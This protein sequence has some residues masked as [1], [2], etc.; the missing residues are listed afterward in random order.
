M[1]YRINSN[2]TEMNVTWN[3]QPSFAESYGSVDIVANDSWGYVNL[4]VTTLVQAWVNGSYPNYGIML[5]GPEVSGSDSSWREFYTR[6]GSYVP[7]LVITY[8]GTTAITAA[9]TNQ[10][11]LPKNN[12][13]IS[14]VNGEN[15][16]QEKFAL[17]KCFV[18]R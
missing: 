8:S 12:T 10:E 5:R 16:C 9:Q 6:H 7:K 4:D 17:V 11:I 3:N 15:V 14:I 1:S 2:W 13:P 18:L